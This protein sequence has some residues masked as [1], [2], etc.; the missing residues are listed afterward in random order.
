MQVMVLMAELG[1]AGAIELGI[2]LNSGAIERLLAYA[3]SVAH[4]PT[5]VKEVYALSA[6]TWDSLLAIVGCMCLHMP[7]RMPA[8]TLA[9]GRGPYQ[10][11]VTMDSRFLAASLVGSWGVCD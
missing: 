5:A 3:E 6:D 8:S 10:F 1:R 2:Q 4:F 11:S 7:A 9:P